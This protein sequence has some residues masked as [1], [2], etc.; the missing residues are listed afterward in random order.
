MKQTDTIRADLE[1]VVRDALFDMG[2]GEGNLGEEQEKLLAHIEQYILGKWYA[3]V[4]G[5]A[6]EMYRRL[7]AAEDVCALVG[8]TGARHRSPREKA[9]S[10]LWN[11]W[12][13]LVGPNAAEPSEY[14]HLNDAGIQALAAQFDERHAREMEKLSKVVV[15]ERGDAT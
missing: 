7:R 6:A 13:D 14:P 12:H 3:H 1:E 15:V 9:L 10:I 2:S 5:P 11:R 4:T 8:W